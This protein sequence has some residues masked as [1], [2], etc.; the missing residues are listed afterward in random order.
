MGAREPPLGSGVNAEPAICSGFEGFTAIVGSLSWCSS[1][2]RA[3]G[4]M[5]TSRTSPA[6]RRGARRERTDD[7][8][9]MLTVPLRLAPRLRPLGRG[10][11][12][13][14]ASRIGR[15]VKVG[16]TESRV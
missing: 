13:R 12:G 9:A 16:G 8:R 7:L 14:D 10:D 6:R 1:P 3:F 2:L 11:R 15:R 5:L 4:I